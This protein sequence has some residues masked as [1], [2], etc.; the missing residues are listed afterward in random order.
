MSHSPAL[1][2]SSSAQPS[3]PA[4]KIIVDP[5]EPLKPSGQGWSWNWYRLA[6]IISTLLEMVV[7]GMTI[8]LAVEVESHHK[9]TYSANLW[10]LINT[11]LGLLYQLIT[12]IE[13]NRGGDSS[14]THL[15]IIIPS[16]VLL[17]IS[18]IASVILSTIS[19]VH[20]YAQRGTYKVLGRLV[21]G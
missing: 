19:L 2:Q 3:A 6:F 1:L 16:L 17:V 5:L 7:A 13:E 14:L 21:I 20:D 9:L 4:S 8:Y 11:T 12:L 15:R 10:D 18:G